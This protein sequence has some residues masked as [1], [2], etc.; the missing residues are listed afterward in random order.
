MQRQQTHWGWIAGSLLISGLVVIPILSILIALFAPSND[1]WQHIS[2]TILPSYI[3]N[4]LLLMLLVGLYTS[5]IGVSTAWLTAAME[6]PGR[7][8]FSWA[9]MLPLAAPAYIVA[10]VYTDLLDYSGPVQSLFRSLTGLSAGEY[11]FPEIRSLPGAALVIGLVLYPYVY[12]LVRVAFLQRSATLYDAARTLG[13]TPFRAFWKIALPA[14]RPALIGGLALVLME[15]LADFGVVDYFAVPTFSTGIFRSW[16][17]MGD[18]TAAMKLAAVMFSFVV[19]L[20]ALEKYS[21]REGDVQAL[22]RDAQ[23]RPVKLT[24]YKAWLATLVCALPLLLG[25]VIPMSALVYFAYVE[26]DP[27]LGFGF[28]DYVLNSL[29]IALLATLFAVTVALVLT[30][31][32]RVANSRVINAS[33]QL[34]TLGYALPGAL[35]AVGLFAPVSILDRW[36]ADWFD[37]TLG[38]RTGLILTGTIAILVYA[39]VVRFLTVAFNSTSSGMMRIPRIYDQAARSLGATPWGVLKWIHLPLMRRSVLAAGIL[40]FV[41]SMRELPATLLLRPFNFETLATRVYRLASDERLA[42]ASTASL[43]IVLIGL[44]PVLMLNRISKQK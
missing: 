2:S 10:Y 19:V 23:L 26:G 5:L 44:V 37:E 33:V 22:A 13:A 27:T 41:D 21:R 18:K 43:M 12:L 1:T 28:S 3:G 9:L 4:T 20:I 7:R 42:E 17:S 40:V 29:K 25:G 30:Y 39:Y 35:L 6:F 32:Q 24:G 16:F 38:W 34:S 8:F 14:A 31:A 11:A 36:L 15:T